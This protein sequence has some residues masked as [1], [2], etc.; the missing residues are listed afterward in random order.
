MS[1]DKPLE[2]QSVPT[3]YRDSVGVIWDNSPQDGGPE[4][5]DYVSLNIWVPYH[6]YVTTVCGLCKC[7]LSKFL[8]F[9]VS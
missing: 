6:M 8:S 4:I 9:L 2:V 5:W 1:L 7:G 3:K